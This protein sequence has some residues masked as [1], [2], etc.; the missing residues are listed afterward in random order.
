MI[1]Y[2]YQIP[3]GDIIHHCRGLLREIAISQE[4]MIYTGSFNRDHVHMLISMPPQLS[5]S[6][7]VQHLKGKSSR[8]LLTEYKAI[9]MRYWSQHLWARGYRVASGGKEYIKY[10]KPPEPDNDFTVV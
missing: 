4:M 2:R 1:K 3:E 5:V 7:A 6:R 10:Q 8:R 9:R